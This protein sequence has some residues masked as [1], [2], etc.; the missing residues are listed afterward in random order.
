TR[1]VMRETMVVVVAGLAIGLVA[2]IATLRLVK[3]MLFGLA[4]TD[5]VSI[6]VAVVLMIM[7]AAL[8]GY[9][10]ARRA[11]RVDPMVALRY[12]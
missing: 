6:S 8:A 1:M 3:S 7:V 11:A 5:P 10:P 9:L 2:A 12:E 4:P